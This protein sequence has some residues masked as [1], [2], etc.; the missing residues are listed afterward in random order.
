MQWTKH[1]FRH[2]VRLCFAWSYFCSVAWH[3]VIWRS[4]RRS[5][6]LNE[7]MKRLQQTGQGLCE[8]DI[9]PSDCVLL[10]QMMLY[11][12]F[13]N[14]IEWDHDPDRG[15]SPTNTRSQTCKQTLQPSIPVYTI[16]GISL[17]IIRTDIK[18]VNELTTQKVVFFGRKTQKVVS[19]LHISTNVCLVVILSALVGSFW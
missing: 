8:S 10:C 17:V 11:S 15:S 18:V 2:F 14:F 1:V 16:R 13:D 12:K 7:R 19:Y 9:R 4:V 5:I 6:Y 3:S